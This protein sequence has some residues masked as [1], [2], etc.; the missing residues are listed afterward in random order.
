MWTVPGKLWLDQN[1]FFNNPV[2]R[3]S[4]LITLPGS[5]TQKCF[6]NVHRYFSNFTTTLQSFENLV[7]PD[8]EHPRQH[9]KSFSA[10]RFTIISIRDGWA[11]ENSSSAG[12]RS[13]Y[14]TRGSVIFKLENWARELE[15]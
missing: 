3:N 8:N 4:A 1:R 14:S 12:A 11:L 6:V 13:E 2:N 15:P 10:F 7:S 5:D 9:G